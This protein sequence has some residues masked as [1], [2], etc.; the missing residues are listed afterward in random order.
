MYHTHEKRVR[1]TV[2]GVCTQRCSPIMD[3]RAWVCVYLSFIH[4]CPPDEKSQVGP[5]QLRS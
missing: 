3:R 5:S 1:L 4:P 2:S